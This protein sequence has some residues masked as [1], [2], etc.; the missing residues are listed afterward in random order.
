[1]ARWCEIGEWEQKRGQG[2]RGDARRIRRAW[3]GLGRKK[4]CWSRKVEVG[5]VSSIATWLVSSHRRL[6]LS[7]FVESMPTVP[8]LAQ[9]LSFLP[10]RLSQHQQALHCQQTI[11]RVN[12]AKSSQGSRRW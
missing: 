8:D 3:A 6:R 7:S 11:D 2:V 1:M 9:R 10:Q 12:A 5:L 4:V